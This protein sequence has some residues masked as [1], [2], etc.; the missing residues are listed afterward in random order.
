MVTS[1]SFGKIA[2]IGGKT[3]L[4]GS[5]SGID[6]ASLIT[7][8]TAARRAPAVALETKQKTLATQST[9]FASL[10]TLLAKF[11]DSADLLRNAP[12]SI[13]TDK[14]L[15][16]YRTVSLNAQNTTQSG[17]AF[18]SATVTAGT[19]LQT[20]SVSNVTQLAQGAIN[21]IGNFSVASMSSAVVSSGPATPGVLQAG[22]VTFKGQ[23]LTFAD[24]DTL[25][26]VVDQF[27]AVKDLTGV[28]AAAVQ[29]SVS[30]SVYTIKLS[31][32]NI[33]AVND[34]SSANLT[35]VGGVFSQ[36]NWNNLQQ[37][38][39]AAFTLD[40]LDVQRPT[41]TITDLIPGVTLSL[42][43]PMGA[44]VSVNVGVNAD[45]TNIKAGITNMLDD[46]NSLRTFYATQTA[47]NSD[48]TPKSTT[49]ADGT[50][51]VTAVLANDNTL[52]SIMN[53]LSNEVSRLVGGL[54]GG[55]YNKL[56]DIGVKLTD[57]AGD[58]VTPATKNIL[59]LDDVKL[60][61][62]LNTNF[63]QV[64]NM[65]QFSSST[66]VPSLQVFKRTNDLNLTDFTADLDPVG[67]VYKATYTLPGASTSTTI[68]LT[69]VDIN[70]GGV[71]LTG[72]AGSPIAGLQMI[73]AGTSFSTGNVH[74][75]QG[76]ADRMYNA[77]DTAT[78]AASGT[79]T[80]AITALA[81]AG[82]RYT[83][84]ITKIDDKVATYRDQLVEKFAKLESALASVNTILQQLDA[85][86]QARNNQ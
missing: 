57:Y 65:F 19:P 72:P 39:D 21:S 60:T 2:S 12:A 3:V 73:F 4:S 20:Y 79:L 10:K 30:P 50:K 26:S 71:Q 28:T 58:D 48:G 84:D 9:A 81:T 8:L 24:G 43:Q 18:I 33:G 85:Q 66:T 77:L 68:D 37:G 63:D 14:N 55:S 80:N 5:N 54:A 17:D 6:T 76:I 23:T 67:K 40:G 56:S 49:E 35:D 78:N 25:Q 51:T 74:L 11:Q 82:T 38:K 32:N 61:N 86:A 7:T 22:S 45:L 75:S 15:F 46:Y 62:A 1:I 59:T 29:T 34:F 69:A 47:R 31:S 16:Q 52:R 44:G 53:S 70:G 83:D 13:N 42:K 36:V 64:V 41:N 27:N